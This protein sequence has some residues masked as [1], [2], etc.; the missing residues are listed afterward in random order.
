MSDAKA[1]YC[2]EGYAD[3]YNETGDLILG[4]WRNNLPVSSCFNRIFAPYRAG[5]N[6]TS[7]KSVREK[8]K[9]Y[10]NSDEGSLLWQNRRIHVALNDL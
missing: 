5:R 8:V 4:S 2:P 3:E 7:G 6:N 10:V 1:V 9:I